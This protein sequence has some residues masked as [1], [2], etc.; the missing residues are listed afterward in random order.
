[1]KITFYSTESTLELRRA[2]VKNIDAGHASVSFSL[3]RVDFE[4]RVGKFASLCEKTY[5]LTIHNKDV[6]LWELSLI[7]DAVDPY[8]TY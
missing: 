1:M 3:R 5:S 6:E 4:P 8:R 2:L 7:L